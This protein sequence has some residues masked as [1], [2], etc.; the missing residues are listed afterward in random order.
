MWSFGNLAV[1]V[2][3][4]EAVDAEFHCVPPGQWDTS[5]VQLY[6]WRTADNKIIVNKPGKVVVDTDTG[7]LKIRRVNFTDSGQLF[8]SAVQAN[9]ER[10]TFE[11]NLIGMTLHPCICC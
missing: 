10:I 4:N 9:E 1:Y 2:F 11:H 6:E 5:R 7:L 8:C 3:G